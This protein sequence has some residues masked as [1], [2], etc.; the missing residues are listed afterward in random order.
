[1][2]VQL[3][4]IICDKEDCKYREGCMVVNSVENGA[5]F[6]PTLKLKLEGLE[7]KVKCY[8]YVRRYKNGRRIFG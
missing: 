8:S 2:A 3:N 5:T 6:S 1:M 7:W 4:K